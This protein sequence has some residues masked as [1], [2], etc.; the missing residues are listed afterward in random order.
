MATTDETASRAKSVYELPALAVY[1]NVSPVSLAALVSVVFSDVFSTGLLSA[2]AVCV[3]LAAGA[4]VFA[5]DCFVSAACLGCS[6]CGSLAFFSLA[7]A[8]DAQ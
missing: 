7:G 8:T 6:G 4:V 2:C 3:C 5:V 1:A